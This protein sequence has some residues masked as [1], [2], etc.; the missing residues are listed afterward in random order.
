VKLTETLSNSKLLFDNF[1]GVLQGALEQEMEQ[2]DGAT[3]EQLRNILFSALKATRGVKE[4]CALTPD[5]SQDLITR[6]L[7]RGRMLEIPT[8]KEFYECPAYESYLTDAEKKKASDGD[9]ETTEEIKEQLVKAY[10]TDLSKMDLFTGML[11]ERSFGDAGHDG[12]GFSKAL[13]AAHV[14]QFKRLAESDR[15]FFENMKFTKDDD[16]KYQSKDFADVIQKNTGL[17]INSDDVFSIVK[18]TK[19]AL[20]D[21]TII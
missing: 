11:N 2:V 1:N 18:S 17:K 19:R 16:A 9:I 8:F 14:E 4:G 3:S 13:Q 7:L 15:F 10:G 5:G 12:A 6:N 20:K 21:D